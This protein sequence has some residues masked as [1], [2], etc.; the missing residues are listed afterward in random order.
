MV[1]IS[2]LDRYTKKPTHKLDII[3][4]KLL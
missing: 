4:W 3:K 2:S 1:N